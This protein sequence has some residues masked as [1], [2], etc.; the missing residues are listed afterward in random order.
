MKTSDLL[1][2]LLLL[3]AALPI[4]AQEPI[5]I[6]G[7]VMASG[8]GGALAA[9]SVMADDGS[10]GTVTN[11]DGHFI[12]KAPRATRTITVSHLGYATRTIEVANAK[13]PLLIR[14]QP[15]TIMLDEI[16]VAD[17]AA[18]LREAIAR[19]PQ[20]YA[21]QPMLQRCFYRETTRKGRRYIY[22]AEAITDMYKRAYTQG[23]NLDRVGILKARRLVSTQASD[24]LGAKIA[25]GP[26]MPV[27]LDIVKNTEYLLNSRVLA[28]YA[29]DMKPA[30]SVDGQGQVVVSITPRQRSDEA[31]LAADFYISTATLAITHVDMKL[32]MSDRERATRFMLRSKPAG[33]RFTPR[34]LE[35]HLSYNADAEGRLSLN[36]MRSDIDFK[37]DW[38]RR[39]FSSPYRVTA[40]MVVTHEAPAETNPIR[41]KSSF[42]R[43]EALYDHPEYFG[44]PEFWEQYNI[45]APTESL[46]KG[47]TR[48]IKHNAKP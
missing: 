48:F 8:R 10:T 28:H 4:S 35:I 40:E 43:R 24:T 11:D 38:K 33:V 36:Y 21:A 39:L 1:L 12:L 9:V 32:D 19:V 13:E 23:I 20:N 31:L 34:N 15:T 17:P 44:D 25:G 2:C 22:V 3:L 27:E 5:T 47:I 18:L 26:V 6:S 30:P 45:I 42:A 14:L 29:F 7:R 46:E 41:G 16:V 37:C